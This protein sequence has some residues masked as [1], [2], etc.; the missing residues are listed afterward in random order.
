MTSSSITNR[1]DARNSLVTALT[2]ITGLQVIYDHLPKTFSGQSPIC[3]VDAI[4]QF[5][6]FNA[7]AVTE[8][9]QFAIGI[10]VD[11]ADAGAA[12]DLL[13]D[14]AQ[15][16]AE[17]VLAWHNGIFYQPSEATYE[18][19]EKGQY[20]VEWHFVQVDWE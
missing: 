1:K 4:S 14:L 10:W 8:T 9:F 19:L 18:E 12:E 13:D 7:P 11:R 15:D 17:V 6:D 20:R 3:T 16:V 2:A 5:P